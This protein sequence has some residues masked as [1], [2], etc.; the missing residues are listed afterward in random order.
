M[1]IFFITLAV[2]SSF[3]CGRFSDND[4]NNGDRSV[5]ESGPK[6]DEAAD[7]P[8]GGKEDEYDMQE[9]V[10]LTILKLSLSP[11]R[12][13]TANAVDVS[14]FKQVLLFGI[15]SFTPFGC[16]FQQRTEVF[17]RF[18]LYFG[19]TSD[20]GTHLVSYLNGSLYDDQFT[21]IYRKVVDGNWMSLRV[22]DKISSALPGEPEPAMF[23]E[24]CTGEVT[25]KVVG[26]R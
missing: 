12:V 3:G 6:G 23:P 24:S 4:R 18:E 8:M 17:N 14:G 25:L 11:A 20:V 13:Q 19:L 7:A 15:E 5:N 22:I 16:R 10:P 21:K 1:R 26:V 9:L 2:L